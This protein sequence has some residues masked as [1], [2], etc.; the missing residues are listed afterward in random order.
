VKGKPDVQAHRLFYITI[1]EGAMADF[2]LKSIQPG[3]AFHKA[4]Y[5]GPEVKGEDFIVYSPE[6]RFS[7]SLSATLS[8]WKVKTLHN[9]AKPGAGLEEAA[10]W[11]QNFLVYAKALYA[12]QGAG[13]MMLDYKSLSKKIAEIVTMGR[14]N[15]TRLLRAARNSKRPPNDNYLPY[16]AAKTT[17][18]ALTV[19]DFLKLPPNQLIDL[20]VAAMIHEIGMLQVPETVLT[21]ENPLNTDEET[22]LFNHPLSA[23]DTLERLR[24][25]SDICL[26][27][28]EHHERENGTG[29]PRKLKGD[30]ITLYA[31]ILAAACSCDALASS[32]PYR[33]AG[34][35]F[36]NLMELL[37]NNGG[38]YDPTVIKALAYSVV[39]PLRM[40]YLQEAS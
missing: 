28:V 2:V 22:A 32:R 40:K 23:Y 10:A 19:G 12:P 4:L 13:E 34:D 20:G 6:L 38:S 18:I 29:Y 1:K 9:D 39:G 11:Y 7:K 5:L 37:K 21:G 15:M 25:P 31:K 27:V 8:K 16:H 3:T 26:A 14:E 33:H 17:L 35:N 30:E 36:A 24:F